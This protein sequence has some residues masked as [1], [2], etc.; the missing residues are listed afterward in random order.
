MSLFSKVI[1]ILLLVVSTLQTT[2]AVTFGENN[3]H[4]MMTSHTMSADDMAHCQE[5][6]QDHQMAA[7]CS[8]ECDCCSGAC[9]VS[10]LFINFSFSYGLNNSSSNVLI[11]SPSHP[12]ATISSLYRPPINV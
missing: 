2:A 6:M 1:C 8:N 10:S 4:A 9:P 7:E 12:I 11:H 3:N 5:M